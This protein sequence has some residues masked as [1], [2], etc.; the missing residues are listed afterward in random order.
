M[1]RPR[2]LDPLRGSTPEQRVTSAEIDLDN[3]DQQLELLRNTQAEIKDDVKWVKR[4]LVGVLASTT[5][6]ALLL[7]SQRFTL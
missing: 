2:F 1:A 4:L 3:H 7:A 6:A 5:G